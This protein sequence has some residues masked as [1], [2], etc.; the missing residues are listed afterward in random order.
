MPGELR[1]LDRVDAP[2]AGERAERRAEVLRSHLAEPGSVRGRL[3]A[4]HGEVR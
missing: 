3:D 2:A 4:A 1:R